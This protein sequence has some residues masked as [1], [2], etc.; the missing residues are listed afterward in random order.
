[1][2]TEDIE[3]F[4]RVPP[5]D[6]HAEAG[7]L[8]GMLLSKDAIPDVH[9]HINARSYYKPGH[10]IIHD[11][12]LELWRKRQPADPI[13]VTAFLTE[14]GDIV[15]VGGPG[16]LHGI[17]N[18]V[19]TA[20]NAEYYAQIVRERHIQRSL[21]ETGTRLVQRGYDTENPDSTLDAAVAELQQ[22]TQELRRTS[23]SRERTLDEMLEEYLEDIETGVTDTL[24]LPYQDLEEVLKPEPGDFI[25]VAARPAVGKTVVLL[26][27]ARHVGIKNRMRARVASME[28]SHKQL[29]QRILAAES[30]V[31]LHKIRHRQTTEYDDR[32]IRSAIARLTGSP[33]VVDDSPAVPLSKLRGRLR[34]LAA[35]DQLPAVLCV[36]YLQIMKAETAAGSNRTGEVDSLAR[37]L[38]E[39]A[40]E[41]RMVV[42]AAAQLNR[43]VEQ[44]PDK[45]PT[46]AD[47]RESGQ[48]EAEANSVVLLYRDEVYNKDSPRAGELDLIVAKNRQGPTASITVAFKSYLASAVDMAGS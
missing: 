23:T 17:V 29:T 4:D 31:S 39:L 7:A 26:D 44:R 34:Q 48:I 30:R 46:M 12:I 27:I 22:L 36:D 24:P 32:E 16:T 37:G 43:Q 45:T 15:R 47:L 2:T 13:T 9:Q 28:M 11:A 14:R 42:I 19:P 21:I 40:Q 18:A 6:L 1:M 20:A 38:K 41:F 33:L 5:Q 25:V 8:G 10:G 35:M 3:T